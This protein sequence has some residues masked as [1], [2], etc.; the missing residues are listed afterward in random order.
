MKKL[1]ILPLFVMFFLVISVPTVEANIFTDV[2]DWFKSLFEEPTHLTPK[3]VEG[4]DIIGSTKINDEFEGNWYQTINTGVKY[5]HIISIESLKSINTLPDLKVIFR[6]TSSN[7]NEI[8]DEKI[9]LY[10]NETYPVSKRVDYDCSYEGN[11][12]ITIKKTCKK[13]EFSHFDSRLKW[14]LLN[15]LD[16][17]IL[18]GSRKQS[19]GNLNFT[20][21]EGFK[22]ILW[23][24]HE[25]SVPYGTSGVVGFLIDGVEYHPPF[26]LN[27]TTEKYYPLNITNSDPN[28]AHHD[29]LI[30]INLTD[31]GVQCTFTDC[32]DL[33]VVYD[34]TTVIKWEWYNNS[35]PAYPAD[36]RIRILF[37]Y[38][39]TAGENNRSFGIYSNSSE[40]FYT[41]IT[42]IDAEE[43]FEDGACSR[44]VDKNGNTI[45]P[46]NCGLNTTVVLDGSYSMFGSTTNAP[47]FFPANETAGDVHEV[48]T[49]KYIWRYTGTNT[50]VYLGASAYP[51]TWAGGELVGLMRYTNLD[52]YVAENS[53]GYTDTGLNHVQ[54]EWQRVNQQL[55]D[56]AN[57]DDRCWFNN[58]ACNNNPYDARV[59]G[60]SDTGGG[61]GYIGHRQW[62]S[63]D[64]RELTDNHKVSYNYPFRTYLTGIPATVTTDGEQEAPSTTPTAPLLN[65]PLDTINISRVT[66]FNWSN[67]TDPNNDAIIYLLEISTDNTFATTA[68][69]TNDSIAETINTTA[70]H[71]VSLSSDSLYY[72][73]AF[74]IGNGENSSASLTRSFTLDTTAPN[75][76]IDA[77][78]NTTVI[79][80]SQ[81]LTTS[82]DDI[83]SNTKWYSQDFGRT[84][85]T[86]TIGQNTSITLVEGNNTIL[87]W[88]NDS[89]NKVNTTNVTL[90]LDITAPDFTLT[91]PSNTTYIT[92]L[93][94]LNYTNTSDATSIM[95]EVTD[96]TGLNSR[97]NQTAVEGTFSV[98]YD[99]S[100][101]LTAYANDSFGNINVSTISFSRLVQ[102]I[103]NVNTTFESNVQE[104]SNQL[105]NA[106]IQYNNY[107]ISHL[108][109][110]FVY[111]GIEYGINQQDLFNDTAEVNIT[112]GIPLV[113]T[114]HTVQTFFWNIT[115]IFKNE[116]IEVN[117]SFSYT[118]T[119]TQMN[120]TLGCTFPVVSDAI[121]V[122][123]TFVTEQ[124]RTV[125]DPAVFQSV[126]YESTFYVWVDDINQ[127]RTFSTGIN[128]ITSTT[129][130]IDPTNATY[131]TNAHIS[132]S[133]PSFDPRDYFFSNAS[134]TNDTQDIDLFLLEI[135]F[136]DDITFTV[137]DPDGRPQIDSVLN[138]QRLDVA[139]NTFSTIAMGKT[140]GAGTSTVFL[141]KNDAWYRFIVVDEGKVLFTSVKTKINADTLNINIPKTTFSEIITVSNNTAYNLQW[142]NETGN[143]ELTFTQVDGKS[144]KGCLNVVR[145]RGLRQTT[146]CGGD[147]YCVDSSSGSITC[148]TSNI[149]GT[150]L[151]IFS[152]G[153]NPTIQ[154]ASLYHTIEEIFESIT[155][156]NG[157]FAF[158][159]IAGTIVLAAVGN[160]VVSIAYLLITLFIGGV[161]GLIGVTG[162]IMTAFMAILVGGGILLF[163][164]KK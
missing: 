89:F 92:N 144:I 75:V 145:N 80:A 105:F 101:T 14:E 9:W 106:S 81:S 37:D 132:Y 159:L 32:A 66:E 131:Q 85:T 84:N 72:W 6:D 113:D 107:S 133:S 59:E 18:S 129:I 164:L 121:A 28:N 150:Y 38:N 135:A 118:Q 52:F 156:L 36:D 153:V 31:I 5:Q 163:K 46:T 119:V 96:S 140:D 97:T 20:K 15:E 71:S 91:N 155:G 122:N 35:V 161:L 78:L 109:I 30:T 56:D 42:I 110:R 117:D 125:F 10:V 48:F 115:E 120:I 70:D 58:T 130:C 98:A 7:L 13:N 23:F 87:F 147:N 127:N 67:S 74:A 54:G 77:P 17:N 79:T 57:A 44:W 11:D 126:N 100:Y 12:S 50:V 3:E 152:V 128:N 1:M 154:L 43:G 65:E 160:P 157:L 158:F 82:V 141:R 142:V 134:L 68:D 88:A 33:Q 99:R 47:Y 55:D 61:L 123:F 45:T 26:Q 86:I 95:Y 34:N 143:F 102:D 138:I 93:I 124:N 29:E 108:D 39:Q 149:S 53:G 8:S 114:D 112:L 60:G 139:N 90:E 69:Y 76:F 137:E 63:S 104:S 64:H 111:G 2:W 24:K 146:V 27:S 4:L 151:A 40:R 21:K 116:T 73:R 62:S 148:H 49:E 41:N 83:T 162:S 16:D 51:S 25:F 19:Y 22:N 94:P 136:A 103:I